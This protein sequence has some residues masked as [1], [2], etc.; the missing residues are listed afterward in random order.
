V[1]NKKKKKQSHDAA[2]IHNEQ[3]TKTAKRNEGS[4]LVCVYGAVGKKRANLNAI[5]SDFLFAF[6]TAQKEHQATL[7]EQ[8]CS[9]GRSVL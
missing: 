7:R 4:P 5:N 6:D 1:E 2:H 8:H 9:A 3:P